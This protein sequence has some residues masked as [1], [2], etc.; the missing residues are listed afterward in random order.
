MTIYETLA[1]SHPKLARGKVWCR[2]CGRSQDVD[3]ADC[4]INGWPKCCGQTMTIDEPSGDVADDAADD[5]SPTRSTRR[6]VVLELDELEAQLAVAVL[7]SMARFI[8]N[9]SAHKER[10]VA[11]ARIDALADKLDRSL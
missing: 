6:V 3:G 10:D 4:L 7:R 5:A 9:H 1:A 11:I 8:D 2:T